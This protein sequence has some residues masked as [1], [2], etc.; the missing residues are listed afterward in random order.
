MP[1]CEYCGAELDRFD[2]RGNEGWICPNDCAFWKLVEDIRNDEIAKSE[3]QIAAEA[4]DIINGHLY[5]AR[6]RQT[7]CW[8]FRADGTHCPGIVKRT[9]EVQDGP[10]GHFCPECGHS[11]RYHKYYGEGQPGDKALKGQIPR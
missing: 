1:V 9:L 5:S 4:E 7:H 3:E 10:Y 2:H 11:L 6:V 8:T